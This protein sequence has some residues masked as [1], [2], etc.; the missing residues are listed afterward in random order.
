MNE[1]L[2]VAGV[3]ATGK[4]WLGWWLAE[5]YEYVHIDAEKDAGSD[6]DRAGVRDE[7][8]ELVATGRAHNFVAAVGGVGKRFIINWGF[9]TRFLY[10]V[11]ALQVAGVRAW[12]LH[13]DRAHARKAFMTRGG[14]DLLCFERQMDD[15]AR[16]WSLIASVF[17]PH[18]VEGL[19]ANG[20]QRTPED[21]WSE[22][23]RAGEH[24]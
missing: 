8:K 1:H 12:W 20:S 17:G 14:I 6:F 10:V 19:D 2:F 5:T 18:I 7:W 16:E 13:G 3:P 4:S 23:A 9:P 15:I 11:S 24:S 21:I 22:I